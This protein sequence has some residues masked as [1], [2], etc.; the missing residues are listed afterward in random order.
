M[1]ALHE[2]SFAS[3]D[4]EI[5]NANHGGN[6]AD[7][8]VLRH[9]LKKVRRAVHKATQEAWKQANGHAPSLSTLQKENASFLLGMDL[10]G[11]GG[12]TGGMNSS[13]N[14]GENNAGTGSSGLEL[15]VR[16]K[17]DQVE[18]DLAKIEKENDAAVTAI[19]VENDEATP[20]HDIEDLCDQIENY[21]Q[22]VAFLKQ[23]SFVR[24]CLEESTALMASA[25]LDYV[26]LDKETEHG[27]VLSA[28]TLLRALQEVAEAER[29]LRDNNNTRNS[30]SGEKQKETEIA[31]RIL[32]SLRHQ[33]RRHRVELV[34]KAGGVLDQNVELTPTSIRLRN[35]PLLSVAY[36]VLETL[37]DDGSLPSSSSS[38][39]GKPK[40]SAMRETLHGVADRL[41][42]EALK[43][44]L[45]A[46]QSESSASDGRHWIA[47]ESAASSLVRLSPD[48]SGAYETR[49]ID[50]T[51]VH[52]ADD[53][54]DKY[55][56]IGAIPEEAD[57]P[58]SFAVVN[59]WKNIL[60]VYEDILTFVLKNVL[61]E[62]ENL[63]S[64][65]GNRLFG[66]P[67]AMP[68]IMNPSALGLKSTLLGEND[69]GVLAEAM[70]G[71]LR[72][73]SISGD[74]W[75]DTTGTT[76]HEA[77]DKVA[78]LR[79]ELL[80]CTLPFCKY[81]EDNHL[82]PSKSSSRLVVFCQDFEKSFVDHRRCERLNEARE[83]LLRNDYHNTT[84]V[85]V[86]ENPS[87][88]DI[89][90]EAL[91][92]FRL[93]RCSISDTAN[94]LVALVRNT[95][96]ECVAVVGVPHDSQLAIL[97]P[98][99][100]KTAREM[101]SLF[102]TII[103]ANYGREVANVPRTAAVLHNDAVFLAHHCLTLGLEY[104]EKF[105]EIDEDDSRGK[106]LKQT[107]IFV[108]MVPLFRELAD[109]SL[110]DMLD[111]QKHQLAE[112]VGSRI[113]YFGQAL[114]SDE[115]VHEW[116]EA[117]TALA[118]GVYHLR[119]LAQ[120]WKSILSTP[121]FLRSM[122][123][124]A[125]VLFSLYLSELTNNGT[126]ISFSARQFAG[127]LFRKAIVDIHGLLFAGRL[128]KSA[129]QDDPTKYSLEWGRFEA[130]GSFLEVDQLVHV[131]QALSS[132]VFRHL[133]SLELAKLV[134]ATYRDSPE[135]KA[136]LNCMTSVV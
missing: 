131:E 61:W 118:A 2:R 70:V 56:D 74:Q 122:G 22:K 94:K 85:G 17:L 49:T 107:C 88:D 91:A 60:K 42:K 93:S 13:M 23:A 48:K 92:V 69:Q 127:T 45:T 111:L 134:R 67:N 83:I 40:T 59:S 1:D 52:G 119:H 51:L 6:T 117:E 86:E 136:L 95:M 5:S 34:H 110:N 55:G 53:N 68:S 84:M 124:L 9:R 33:I 114:R 103:P 123:Y 113:T 125:D 21:R 19:V 109:T 135:R 38:K 12:G 77:L 129:K 39:L 37:D 64:I 15:A 47:D 133:E 126:T 71:W 101:F 4:E 78:S 16:D 36:R 35:S 31:Y 98:I 96:D 100:Y 87:P 24:S 7:A 62:R 72:D 57:E 25:S 54:R 58:S 14:L 115:S 108:D 120:A 102:R 30:V 32:S 89:Q 26:E 3:D 105:P 73:Q 116:S 27:L 90:E 82:I 79:E 132:G 46:L 75:K 112:I 81:L 130:V 11:S 10:F 20:P 121:V 104:K 50:W 18:R 8:G 106:L 97:R 28:Q 43:P 41:F 128:P 80:E 29:I 65:L 63:C 44:I 99:L 66:T 76:G